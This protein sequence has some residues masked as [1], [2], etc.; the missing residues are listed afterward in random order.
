M[1]DLLQ[2]AKLDSE[3]S[4]PVIAQT[5]NDDDLMRFRD[6]Q[7]ERFVRAGLPVATGPDRDSSKDMVFPIL[8]AAVQSSHMLLS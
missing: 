3:L 6:R 2:A 4:F 5:A 8:G 7:A 1:N